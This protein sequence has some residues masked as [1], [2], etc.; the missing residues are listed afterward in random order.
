ML[1]QMFFIMA[2]AVDVNTRTVTYNAD[3][4]EVFRLDLMSMESRLGGYVKEN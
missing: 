3:S 4:M 2:A 1:W